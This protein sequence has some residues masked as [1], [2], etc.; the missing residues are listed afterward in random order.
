MVERLLAA[1]AGFKN[2]K[3]SIGGARQSGGAVAALRQRA[4]ASGCCATVRGVGDGR[5]H[6]DVV[7]LAGKFQPT[8][9]QTSDG[10]RAFSSAR[11]SAGFR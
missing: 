11:P 10:G 4:P 2:T 3:I 8:R 7:G 6:L 9:D 5:R 1:V